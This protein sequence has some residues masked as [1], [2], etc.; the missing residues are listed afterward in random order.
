MP[1]RIVKIPGARSGSATGRNFCVMSE[2]H[3]GKPKRVRKTDTVRAT[4]GEPGKSRASLRS[5]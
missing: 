2:A 1:E 3:F 4:V 5:F